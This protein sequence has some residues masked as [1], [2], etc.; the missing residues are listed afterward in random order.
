MEK[1]INRYLRFLKV[2]KNLADNS[3]ES[4]KLD[5]R[6]FNTFLTTNNI[7]DFDSTTAEDISKYLQLLYD[8]GLSGKTIARNLSAIRML[9][10]YMLMDGLVRNNPAKLIDSPKI[11]KKLPDVLTVNEVICIIEKPDTKELLGI[12]DKAMLEFVYGTGVRVSE[13]ISIK[14]R[15]IAFK[16]R[17]VRVMGKGSKERIIPC[18]EIAFSSIEKY[19]RESR[20]K[21]IKKNSKPMDCLFLNWRGNP[22]TRMGFWKNLKKYCVLAGINKKISPHTLR[23]SFATH[24]LEG[25]ADLRAVQEMLGHSDISTTQIYTHLDREYLMEIHKS[26]H[27][28]E[29]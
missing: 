5:L 4:Y 16:E 14:V 27:P 8:M 23:H 20:E 25:G 12:R 6:R 3:I 2:E 28:M 26:F 19:I 10:Q 15:D 22:M 18:G 9:F 17:L 1:E 13:L 21:L 11:G 24:L 29:R 7:R